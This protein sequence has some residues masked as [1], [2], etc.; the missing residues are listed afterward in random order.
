MFTVKLTDL[1][2]NFDDHFLLNKVN[3]TIHKEQHWVITGPNGSGKSALAACLVSA[4]EI[5]SGT[6]TGL[7]DN[8]AVVSFEAQAALIE[9]E[10]RKDDADILDVISEGTSVQEMLNEGC[11]NP[12]ELERLITAFKFEHLLGRSFRKL[13]TGETRKVILMKALICNAEM[14]ILDEPFEGLDKDSDALL[15]SL[16]KEYS[17]TTP[18]V[19]VLNRFDEI[20]DFITHIAYVD[21]ATLG[22]TVDRSNANEV[23]ELRQLLH[24]KTSDLTIPPTVANDASETF[25]QG[26]NLVNIADARIAYGDTV[27]FDDLNWQIKAGEHWQVSGPNGS[28]KTCLLNLITGDHP[29]CYVN[30]ISVFG[31]Q[32][33]NGE[34][35]WDIKQHIGYVSSALQWE[36]KVS[37]SVRNA[38]VSGFFDSIGVYQQPSDEQKIIADQW[39][40][41]LGL[42][43]VANKPFSQLSFGDQ[44]LI[45][46]ARA[47]VK[48]PPL[49]I[50]DEPCLGLD[51]INRHLVLALIE[52]I[53]SGSD[54]SV[55]YVNHRLQDRIP[56]IRW[57]MELGDGKG[58][59]LDSLA[60]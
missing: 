45:L 51:D 29:Q 50:L 55:L 13:S 41:L 59:V 58:R 32:R 39:L 5:E 53:C 2:V 56:G 4:G 25:E 48:H 44:R 19:L 12:Q 57:H 7:P 16:L 24:I 15:H 60:S 27:I 34:T 3:W 49:L 33:G 6:I 31:M 54:T 23:D 42:Q 38:I 37:V 20:P 18:L 10:R 28:G 21:Q 43:S 22:H 9:A 14:I 46:I 26:V 11:K 17:Q 47:M 36:Y 1:T 52:K 30:D 40:A 35:I 8:I